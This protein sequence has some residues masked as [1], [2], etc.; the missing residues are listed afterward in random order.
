MVRLEGLVNKKNNE[1]IG[2][3]IHDLPACSIMPQPTTLPHVPCNVFMANVC[4]PLAQPHAGGTFLGLIWGV[5]ILLHVWDQMMWGFIRDVRRRIK[6]HTPRLSATLLLCTRGGSLEHPKL[7][8]GIFH[9]H[10]VYDSAMAG[11]RRRRGKNLKWQS[12]SWTSSEP[13]QCAHSN[14]IRIVRREGWRQV[15]IVTAWPAGP[16]GYTASGDEY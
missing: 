6:I 2:T 14:R 10:F 8:N 5:C 7:G 3:G 4:Y 13:V 1:L 16:S 11:T 15:S 9:P 12:E